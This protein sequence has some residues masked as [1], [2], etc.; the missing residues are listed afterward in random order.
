KINGEMIPKEAVIGFVER[1]REHF[2]PVKASF[3]EWGV[4]LA[5]HHFREENVDIAVLETGMGGRLDSTNVIAPEVSVITNIGWD[6]MDLLGDSLEKIA[7]EKAGI[8]KPGVPV[9][10]GEAQGEVA[11]IFRKKA[12]ELNAPIEFIDHSG[13]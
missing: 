4:A 1:Y 11:E 10:I 9:V 5:L 2:E 7:A 8:I 13:P 12:E 6:H 3:F